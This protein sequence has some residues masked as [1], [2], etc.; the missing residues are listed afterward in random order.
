MLSC[1]EVERAITR[2]LCQPAHHPRAWTHVRCAVMRELIKRRIALS[3]V[4]AARLA[5]AVL[6]RKHLHTWLDAIAQVAAV[7]IQRIVVD[8]LVCL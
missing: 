4:A 6:Y 7:A 2:K 5:A 8:E 1:S 3:P